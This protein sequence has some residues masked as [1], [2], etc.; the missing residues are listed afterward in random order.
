MSASRATSRETLLRFG[1]MLKTLLLASFAIA[2]TLSSATEAAAATCDRACLGATLDRYLDAL[3][4]HD[5]S[6]AP[7]S[8]GFRQT[9]NAVVVVTGTGL[10]QSVTKLGALQRRYFDTLTEQAA[11][12]GT[13]DEAAGPVIVTLRLKP[14]TC[15]GVCRAGETAD[16]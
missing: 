2:A 6:V 7:L 16:R 4:K 8:L 5:A 10:W 11:Y 15:D 1:P 3:V 9:E 13:I 12:F 14:A